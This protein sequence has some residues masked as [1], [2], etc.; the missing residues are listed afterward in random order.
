MKPEPIGASSALSTHSIGLISKTV[1]GIVWGRALS[2]AEGVDDAPQ[3]A[4]DQ[5]EGDVGDE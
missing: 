1:G 4:Y 5:G 3:D 2:A